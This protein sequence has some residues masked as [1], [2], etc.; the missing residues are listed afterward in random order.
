[1]ELTGCAALITGGKRT[2]AA[3][4][5]SAGAE[6]ALVLYQLQSEC[7]ANRSIGAGVGRRVVA[8]KADL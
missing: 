3:V 6:V 2:G 8:I 5:A 1:M 7:R 4:L